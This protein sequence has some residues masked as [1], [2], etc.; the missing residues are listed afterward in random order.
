[1]S[2]IKWSPLRE[3]E[4]GQ[5][6]MERLFSD[7]F[8]T[9]PRRWY[10][11][12]P[13]NGKHVAI[14]PNIEIYEKKDEFVVKAELPGVDKKDI[15]LTI[16]HDNLTLKGEVKKEEEVKEEK[17]YASERYYG[18]FKRTIALPHEIDS[19]KAKANYK[20]GLLEVILPRKEEAKPKKIN[21]DLS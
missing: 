18:N 21:V 19:E 2:L 7:F 13:G 14:A 4:H 10:H 20:N 15:E 3:M 1:M 16:N 8:D 11:L 9:F 6:D 5:R 17:Y 12:R